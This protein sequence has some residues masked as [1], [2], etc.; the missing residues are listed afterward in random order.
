MTGLRGALAT[1]ARQRHK[2]HI[3]LNTNLLSETRGAYAP[4]W[5]GRHEARL[6]HPGPKAEKERFKAGGRLKSTHPY[7]KPRYINFKP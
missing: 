2:F 7:L 5:R 3:R 1:V 6:I 4:S